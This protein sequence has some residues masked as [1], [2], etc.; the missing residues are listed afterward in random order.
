MPT[1]RLIGRR[2]LVRDVVALLAAGRSVLLVGPAG[3]GKTALIETIEW[4][5][6]FVVD[7]F[8][9][10]TRAAAARIRRGMNRGNAYLAAA[11]SPARSELG[12]VGRIAWRM[13]LAY[14][15][16][17]PSRAVR[18]IL[19]DALFASGVPP[20]AFDAGWLRAA[21]RAS[22]GLPGRALA[23]SLVVGERW[24]H[25]GYLLPVQS[26]LVRSL[27]DVCQ[28]DRQDPKSTN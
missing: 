8:E 26:A 14:V 10:I 17:L 15:R 7:P 9:R 28:L 13:T 12:C 4:P 16:P 20:T 22:S 19:T 6:D 21:V 5:H 1:G 27:T 3:V 25:D 18:T 2:V 11:R 24:R 23:L